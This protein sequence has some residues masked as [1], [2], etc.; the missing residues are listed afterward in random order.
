[1]KQDEAT[2]KLLLTLDPGTTDSKICYRIAEG[3]NLSSFK[4]LLMN[5]ITTIVSRESIE[6][7]ENDRITT[8]LPESEAWVRYEDEYYVT[9]FL[10]ERFGA[11][12]DKKALKYEGAITKVLATVGA[13]AL[14]EGLGTT[15]DLALSIVLPYSEWE[16]RDKVRVELE[17]AL[18]RFWFRDFEFSVNLEFFRCL[19]EGG[20]LLLT[21]GKKLGNAFNE[22]K[23][24][25]LMWG[26]RDLSVLTSHRTV[27]DGQTGKLGF[28]EMLEQIQKRTSGLE[29]RELL[30][31][32]HSAGTKI[33]ARNFKHLAKSQNP[34]RRAEEVIGIAE[35]IKRVRAD[36]WGRVSRWLL[37]TLP[38][39]SQEIVIGGGT[40]YYFHKELKDFLAQNYQETKV[41][42][43]ADLEKDVQTVFNLDPSKDSICVRL[44]DAYGVF[45]FMQQQLFPKRNPI[46]SRARR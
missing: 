14:K 34:K 11:I 9:G 43:S 19:P 3:G 21:R 13:I 25:S 26:Y 41:Y 30:Y 20:G 2:P 15:I 24:I 35:A 45:R 7:Y 31:A 10:A 38:R 5:S 4:L 23:I 12:L 18:E 1:M 27:M 40:A 8:P 37:M 44:A 6:A 22:S 36:Y 42:W 17:T 28:L 29:E 33:T 46:L 39:D 32:V 16:D